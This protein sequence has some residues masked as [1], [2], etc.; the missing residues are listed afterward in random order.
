MGFEKIRS[1]FS[2][3]E[4]FI[5][6]NELVSYGMEDDLIHIHVVPKEKVE[7][8]FIKFRE[9]LQEIAKIVN[10]NPN[11]KKVSG[12]SW[13]VA[14]NAE[15]LERRYGFTIDGEIDEKMRKEHFAYEKR[16][17]WGMHIDREEFLRR[18]LIN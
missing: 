3:K 6:A 8:I 13:L 16:K 7:N 2:P 12:S 18:Y 14:E 5:S 17:V 1:S 9:G 4:K 15:A 11:I 10:E